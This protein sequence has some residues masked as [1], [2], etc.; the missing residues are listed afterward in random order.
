MLCT[1]LFLRCTELLI[2]KYVDLKIP[3]D[4]GKKATPKELHD[5]V[6]DYAK[7][8][9]VLGLLLMEFNDSIW[10]GDGDRIIRCWKFLLPLF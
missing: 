6:H 2:E 10:E 3:D 4:S 5:D 9:L 7:D 1:P 8:T